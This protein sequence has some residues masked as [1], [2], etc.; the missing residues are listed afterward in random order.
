MGRH[1]RHSSDSLHCLRSK[2]Q[3]PLESGFSSK[4]VKRIQVYRVSG[5]ST[6]EVENGGVI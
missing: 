5:L 1:C 4:S 2:S 3:L 6:L